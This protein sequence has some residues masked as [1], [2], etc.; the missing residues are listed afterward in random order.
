VNEPLQVVLRCAEGLRS[1][2]RY[3][4]DTLFMA[5]GIP[6]VYTEEPAGSGPWVF[7]GAPAYVGAATDRCLVLAHCPDAWGFLERD[8]T[9]KAAETFDGLKVVLPGRT[10]MSADADVSFD[11]VANAFYFLSSWSERPK[12]GK[13]QSRQLYVDSVFALLNV[14]QDIVDQ[15]LRRV[16]ELLR[17][18]CDRCGASGWKPSHWPGKST[19]AIV[20]SHD[21]DFLPLGCVDIAKQGVRTLLRH[22]VRQRDVEDALRSVAGLAR[23]LL[24]GRDPYG[25]I[26]DIIKREKEMGV[27]ASFQVAVGHRHPSD[28]NYR[29]ESDRVRDYLRVIAESGF[30]VCL[31]G[32]VRSTENPEWYAD[33]VEL[34]ARRLSRPL[35][36][37]QHF[38]SF[39]YDRLF[40]VQEQTGILYDMSMGFPDRIGARAGFSYPYFPYCMAKDRPYNVVQISL[41]LMDVTLQ[42]Y[43]N[44]KDAQA[45][46]VIVGELDALCRKGGCVSV[47]WH[48][49]VFAGARDPG[50][51]KLFWSMV[52][53]VTESGG[54]ATDGQTINEFWRRRATGYVSFNSM[55]REPWSSEY[56][57]SEFEPGRASDAS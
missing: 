15:Y 12:P 54:I 4:L 30:D 24:Q 44:L 56:P 29:I 9:I 45:W 28:V 37:R 53:R 52:K 8:A 40:S 49:I 25:C 2:V 33:E 38:L 23:A 47:V 19:H 17:A 48:P 35:G 10:S 16:L 5:V 20:L 1:K 11:I 57:N 36:S 27:R 43:M 18:V 51:D 21:I 39:D 32:S 3:V 6:I 55:L 46:Q 26:P 14:P 7:Y 31:H 42:G 22:L 34:L 13:V 41:F 50:Y